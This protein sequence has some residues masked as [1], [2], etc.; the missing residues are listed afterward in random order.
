MS[1]PLKER[2]AAAN[3][4][5]R[6]GDF[7]QAEQHYLELQQIEPTRMDVLT[8]LG[9]ITLWKN[10]ADEAEQYFKKAL[11]HG[12]WLARQWPFSAQL[13]TSLA[14]TYYRQ[15]RF[16]QAALCFKEAAGPLPL[17]PF[18]DLQALATQLA[19]FKGLTPYRIEGLNR[20]VF[21]LL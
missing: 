19:L 5:Y 4:L 18:R 20:F 8:R 3:A 13:K 16:A 6:A 9:E 12:S 15:D 2:L 11:Y 17:G 21:R 10:C 7:N 1:D 14:M